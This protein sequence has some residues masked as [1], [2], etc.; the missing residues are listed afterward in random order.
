MVVKADLKIILQANEVVIAES[1]DQH[2]WQKVLAAINTGTLVNVSK[3]GTESD[4]G[5]DTAAGVDIDLNALIAKFAKQLNIT[6]E[7]AIGSCDPSMEAPYLHLDKHHWENLKK[8]TPPRGP[9]SI[10]ATALTMTLLALWKEIAGL[11]GPTMKEARDVRE[12]IGADDK[13]PAR[14]V[15]NCEW[16]QERNSRIR[17]NPSKTSKAISVARAYCQKTMITE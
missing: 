10:S 15:K 16:L 1:D 13:S 14:S 7:E 9:N 2:L 6:K 11:E 12:T 5:S 17:I 8:S 3:L 4:L